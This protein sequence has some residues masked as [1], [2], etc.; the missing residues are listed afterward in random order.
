MDWCIDIQREKIIYSNFQR[1][2][3]PSPFDFTSIQI[4]NTTNKIK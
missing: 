1:K 3:A 2:S 4:N